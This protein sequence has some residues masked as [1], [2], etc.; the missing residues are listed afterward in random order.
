MCIRDRQV[1]VSNKISKTNYTY[2]VYLFGT[3]LATD[4]AGVLKGHMNG[5]CETE[6]EISIYFSEIKN[7][8]FAE[9]SVIYVN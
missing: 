8:E 2:I 4:L 3:H 6:R 9:D 1:Q 5:V 7:N